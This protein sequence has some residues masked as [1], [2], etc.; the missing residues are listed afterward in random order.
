MT[1][2]EV[3]PND[4]K[5]I[6]YAGGQG[7][8][9]DFADN[10]E[11]AKIGQ[12]IYEDGGIV[13]AVCHG[14][15][16]LLNIKLSNGEYL[17]KDKQIC[18]FSDAEEI[19]VGTEKVVPYLLEDAIVERGAIYVRRSPWGNCVTSDQRVITGQNPQ[20]AH[21]VGEAVLKELQK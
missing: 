19:A 9:W 2:A 3:N 4:Y 11:L 7:T 10:I 8:M 14:P 21:R 15:A 20:S 1:P 5:A 17:I 16:G 6:F 18:G 12:Q 13:S